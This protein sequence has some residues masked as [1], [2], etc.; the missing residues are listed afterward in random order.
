MIQC[1]FEILG[2]GVATMDINQKICF[3]NV[4]PVIHSIHEFYRNSL[5]YQPSKFP[6]RWWSFCFCCNLWWVFSYID[7]TI[8]LDQH[9]PLPDP[10]W[11]DRRLCPKK[12]ISGQFCKRSITDFS[13]RILFKSPR[14]NMLTT[15]CWTR[16]RN[17]LFWGLT[18]G[19]FLW[20]AYLYRFCE[21]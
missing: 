16:V 5:N 21:F 18:L 7:W 14:D 4:F 3:I 11:T 12:I 2:V 15:H 17:T 10:K 9:K 19:N 13:L 6:T 8:Y 1:N 20:L